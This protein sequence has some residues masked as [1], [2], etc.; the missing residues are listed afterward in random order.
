MV[1]IE[2]KIIFILFLFKLDRCEKTSVGRAKVLS[3]GD[4]GYRLAEVDEAAA[5][6]G[7]Q[8]LSFK[9]NRGNDPR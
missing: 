2:K 3:D 6:E 8:M 5:E 4:T 9:F 1:V 7:H